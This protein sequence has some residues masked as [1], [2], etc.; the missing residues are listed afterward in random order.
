[1]LTAPNIVLGQFDHDDF[2]SV[3]ALFLSAVCFVCADTHSIHRALA[4]LLGQV[5]PQV[6]TKDD[7]E[8]SG[9]EVIKGADLKRYEEEGKVASLT[10]DRVSTILVLL[11]GL[12][13]T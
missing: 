12:G 2:W 6:A 4:E 1:M 13:S 5:K 9:L 8:K 3:P 11:W 7:I 10:T